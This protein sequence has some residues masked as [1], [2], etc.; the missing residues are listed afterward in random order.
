MSAVES[1]LEAQ[2]T[3][4]LRRLAREQETRTRRVR[5]EAEAQAADVVRRA[6]GEARSRVRQAVLETRRA[7]EITLARRRAALETQARRSQQAI[8]RELLERAWQALPDALQSRWQDQDSRKHWCAAACAA[9]RRSLRHLDRLQVELDPQWVPE[10][11]T[12]LARS[13][14]GESTVNVAAIAGL[15]AGLRIRAGDACL[16]ATVAGL[17]AARERIAAELLAEFERQGAARGA[18]NQP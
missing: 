7:D 12:A 2:T 18:E 4:L 5:D 13:F 9:A 3:A 10:L 11:G 15:G 1:V 16:D 17:L 8:L 6:R 14:T